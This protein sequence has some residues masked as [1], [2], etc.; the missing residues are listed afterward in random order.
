[1]DDP[2]YVSMYLRKHKNWMDEFAAIL[3]ERVQ[4]DRLIGKILSVRKSIPTARRKIHEYL[5][6]R[7]SNMRL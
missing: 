2:A 4:N 1:M 7:E 5:K 6:R 3:H